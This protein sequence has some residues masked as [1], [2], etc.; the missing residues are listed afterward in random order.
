MFSVSTRARNL[1]QNPLTPNPP[2]QRLLALDALRGLALFGVLVVNLIM[3]FRV[4]IFQQFVAPQGPSG[5]LDDLVQAFVRNVFELKA[6]ALFSL[7]FG[8]GL[9][10]Q[11]ERLQVLPHPRYWLARRLA[12]L[13][14]IG[15]I[16]LI[17]IW[18][19]DVLVSYAVAGFLVLPFVGAPLWAIALAA[20]AMLLM[21]FFMPLL[22]SP[23]AWPSEEMFARHVEQA[24]QVFPTQGYV[25]IRRF[26][27]DELELLLPLHVYI[28]PRTLGLMLLGML[29]W[30]VR[31]WSLI[32]THK[33]FS[34]VASFAAI[35]TGAVISS[36]VS[37]AGPVLLALGYAGF[38]TAAIEFA[39]LRKGAGV[40]APVG[41]M[42]FTNYIIQ[43]VVL[44]WIFFGYGLGLYNQMG[45]A[46]GFALAIA[47]FGVQALFSGW[48]LKHWRFGPIEWLWRSL[49][50][51]KSQ[52]MRAR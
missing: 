20:S 33:S 2:E 11:C 14:V 36:V 27:W 47:I 52:P 37:G 46:T 26:S 40:L 6:Y 28:F 9:A 50:Y 49:M 29:A 32:A 43:S 19:G 41:R 25:E 23:V 34:F 48:W 42:A 44:G 1:S 7:L 31:C 3:E 38:F 24:S 30:R 39:W 51:G 35:V 16:H 8:M 4:S 5:P 45:A 18:N 10:A 17:L 21:Y 12:I 15:A 22:P 13:L